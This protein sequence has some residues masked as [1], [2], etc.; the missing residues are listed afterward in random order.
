MLFVFSLGGHTISYLTVSVGHGAFELCLPSLGILY[1]IN[2]LRTQILGSRNRS[3]GSWGEWGR[4]PDRVTLCMVCDSAYRVWCV[5][6]FQRL[7]SAFRY[8]AYASPATMSEYSRIA[9]IIVCVFN[10]A[11]GKAW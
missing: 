8:A 6:Y 3:G 11:A 1:Q 2:L 5:I 10:S 7:M 4:P 9:V